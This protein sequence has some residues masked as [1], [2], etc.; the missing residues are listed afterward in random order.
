MDYLRNLLNQSLG[1]LIEAGFIILLVIAL[2]IVAKYMVQKIYKR[3]QKS[4]SKIFK[5]DFRYQIMKPIKLM[6]W[7][8]GA[9]Y[10]IYIF[11]VR[12]QLENDFETSFQ[13]FRN[14]IL[15]LGFTWLCFE[16]KS[17][18]M[19]TWPQRA[20]YFDRAPDMT[21]ILLINKLI[22]VS[23]IIIAGL[24]VLDT[25]GVHIGALLALGGVGGVTLGFAARDVFANFFSGLMLHITKPFSVGDW[26]HSLDEK[27]EGRVEQIGFYLTRIRGINKRPFYVPNS[28]FSSQITVNATRMTNR[29]IK[30]TIG[31]RY[32]DFH[33]I[34]AIIDD[35]RR[36]LKDNPNI[37][38]DQDLLVDFV[39]YDQ[40]S[41]NISVV[42][43]TKTTALEEWLQVQQDV[44][45][46]IG[47]I[48]ERHGA[49]IAYPTSTLHINN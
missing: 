38:K 30:Q 40:S 22:S 12:L 8:I 35:I 24:I 47:K 7:L 21:K 37:A 18:L 10:L 25:L 28:L 4:R 42:T 14:L 16:I 27:M 19:H 31:L 46:A 49:E 45:I 44:L 20:R 1:I 26:V 33:C 9:S 39:E 23:I 11:I 13:Q 34:E 29:K 6:I 48:I 3:S 2:T 41:L 32:E 15:I 36:M 5:D 17:Q 43:F